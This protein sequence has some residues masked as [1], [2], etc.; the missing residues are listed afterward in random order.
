[1][2]ETK[3]KICTQGD[4]QMLHDKGYM[5]TGG[6]DAACFY[7]DTDERAFI[8]SSTTSNHNC[9]VIFIGSETSLVSTEIEFTDY[10]GW[11]FHAGGAGKS[12]AIALVRCD[13]EK[14]K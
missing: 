1:M 3:F 9:P 4:I 12:I 2:R 13:A 8:E 7:I 10:P 11:R 6:G 14:D 5:V